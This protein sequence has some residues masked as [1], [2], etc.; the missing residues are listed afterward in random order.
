MRSHT[1]QCRISGAQHPGHPGHVPLAV[2]SAFLP[3][4]AELDHGPRD[5]ITMSITLGSRITIGPTAHQLHGTI[6]TVAYT[7]ILLLLEL[8]HTVLGERFLSPITGFSWFWTTEPT[9]TIIAI[10][11]VRI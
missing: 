8:V 5:A 9:G 11:I 10:T 3:S 4:A 1:N 2:H 7:L 6:H